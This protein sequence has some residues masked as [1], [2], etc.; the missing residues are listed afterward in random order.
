MLLTDNKNKK[1]KFACRLIWDGKCVVVKK[2]NIS[3][4]LYSNLVKKFLKNY[5]TFQ[6]LLFKIPSKGKIV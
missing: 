3:G 4:Y 2:V 5:L 6:I 1:Y